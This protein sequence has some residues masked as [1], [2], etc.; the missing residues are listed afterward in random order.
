MQNRPPSQ[1]K[2]AHPPRPQLAIRV[3]FA[4]ARREFDPNRSGLR[5]EL[6]TALATIVAEVQEQHRNHPGYDANLAPRL[7]FICSLG[8]GADQ[9]AARLAIEH[10]FELQVPLALDRK[11]YAKENFEKYEDTEGEKAFF[12]L[13]EHASTTSIFELN[14]AGAEDERYDTAGTVL[15]NHSDILLAVWDFSKGKG[16]GGTADSVEKARAVD[17]PVVAFHTKEQR[18]EL[19]AQGSDN[20]KLAELRDVVQTILWNGLKTARLHADAEGHETDHRQQMQHL[21]NY[22]DERERRIDW[23]VGYSLLIS[24]IRFEWSVRLRMPEYK[25]ESENS[26]APVSS[27]Y[28]DKDPARKYFRTFDQWADSLAVYYGQ[29]MRGLVATSIVGGAFFVS[30][31]L[32]MN[33][34]PD[35]FHWRYA[36]LLDLIPFLLGGL[37]VYSRTRGVQRRWLQYRLLS[38]LLRNHALC[39]PIGGLNTDRHRLHARHEFPPSWALFYYQAAVRGFGLPK[40]TIDD[41]YLVGYRALIGA[42][43][44]EQIEYHRRQAKKCAVLHRRIRTFGFITF[45]ITLITPLPGVYS[46]LQKQFAHAE[47]NEAMVHNISLI[48]Y[49]FAGISAA[50]AGFAAQENFARLAQVSR[51]VQ[52]RLE[53]LS[54]SVMVQRIDNETLRNLAGDIID[55]TVQEHA[56]WVL[57]TS[58]RDIEPS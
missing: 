23:G 47:L 57:L 3:G 27:F 54:D 8:A 43:L 29:W 6:N 10:G 42:R 16:P 2:A 58:L 1:S 52:K 46:F 13:L 20:R 7:I 30:I 22:Y 49:L 50:I 18:V 4:G 5:D 14:G 56:G 51:V 45:A 53:L 9:F 34:W 26:W 15:V 35:T 11:A 38:E 55:V 36:S 25:K 44:D 21:N 39:E 41:D 31:T 19:R 37:I 48:P 12:E 40:A 28:A 17:V 24:L 33:L 32:A